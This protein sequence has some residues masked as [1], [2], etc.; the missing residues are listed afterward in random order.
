MRDILSL[1][2][3]VS[4]TLTYFDVLDFAPTLEEVERDLYGWSAPRESIEHTLRGDGNFVMCD[5]CVTLKGREHLAKKRMQGKEIEM[6]LWKKV[7]RFRWLLGICPYIRMAA[8]CNSL[9]Y[10]NVHEGSDIDLFIV[11]KSG[12]LNIAR[13]FLKILSQFFCMRAHHEKTAGR[14][15]VSFIVTEHA[16][17][18]KPLALQCDPHLAYFV[19]HMVPIVGRETYLE[20]L[21]S[22]NHWTKNYFKRDSN[23]RL[24]MV[25]AHR[26]LRCVQY[27]SERLLGVFGAVLENFSQNI[28]KRRDQERRREVKEIKAV[29]I[30]KDVYKFH[31]NDRRRAVA[32]EFE[33]R[34]TY[35]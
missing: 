32:E 7:R 2:D 23:P 17:D 1:R 20:F 25:R 29:V 31:E 16:L 19:R 8:V 10:G 5:G 22:N 34:L 26:L 14:F 28:Q 11:V 15:C 18:L 30:T 6:Q 4:A 13:L 12:R 21:M 9:A 27:L 35:S 33:R 24:E 3:A